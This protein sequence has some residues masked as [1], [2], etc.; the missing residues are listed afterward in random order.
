M[1]NTTPA[2]ALAKGDEVRVEEATYR[3]AMGT[4]TRHHTNA[5]DLVGLVGQVYDG[6]PDADGDIEVEFADGALY[7]FDPA[8]LVKVEPEVAKPAPHGFEVGDRVVFIDAGD[9][10]PM[11]WFGALG[12]RHDDKQRFYSQGAT[13]FVVARAEGLLHSQNI[14]IKP[15]GGYEFDVDPAIVRHSVEAPEVH[16]FEPGDRAVVTGTVFHR[17][18]AEMGDHENYPHAGRPKVGD[19]VTI[20]SNVSAFPGNLDVGGWALAAECL[21]PAPKFL[22]GDRV[23]IVSST[24]VG[25]RRKTGN[26]GTVVET[27]AYLRGIRNPEVAVLPDG[28]RNPWGYRESDLALAVE[29]PEPLA[30]WERE[31]L[32]MG[33]SEVETVRDEVTTFSE[34]DRVKVVGLDFIRENR[35]HGKVGTVISGPDADGDYRVTLPGEVNY[36]AASSLALVAEEP[37]AAETPEDY[38]LRLEVSAKASD[39]LSKAGFRNIYGS[40]VA[41]LAEFLLGV[42]KREA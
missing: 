40:D 13:A 22:P 41:A 30:E 19:V 42:A 15:E 33:S 39:I 14:S 34:G 36:F 23:S 37:V 28:E 31:L 21:V 26:V 3:V 38:T 12:Y 27:P 5:S 24:Y 29:A 11:P 16:T 1:S 6:E 8:G 35:D 7:P 18:G 2:L 25:P 17:Y 9:D 10:K 4:V 20:G 32:S